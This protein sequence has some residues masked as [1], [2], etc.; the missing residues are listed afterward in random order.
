MHPRSYLHVVRVSGGWAVCCER[1]Q[2]TVATTRLRDRADWLAVIHPIRCTTTK[3][4]G[5]GR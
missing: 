3:P 2:T 5:V 4:W 1:C